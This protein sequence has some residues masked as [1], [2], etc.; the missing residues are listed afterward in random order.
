MVCVG[1]GDAGDASPL[2]SSCSAKGPTSGSIPTKVAGGREFTIISC[3]R[4]SPTSSAWSATFAL[5][6]LL[7][8]RG[9][10]CCPRS[11]HDGFGGSDVVPVAVSMLSQDFLT[12]L[13]I[14]ILAR[15]CAGWATR[16]EASSTLRARR[17]RM[18]RAGRGIAGCRIPS[19]GIGARRPGF[20]GRSGGG[21]AAR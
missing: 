13:K 6:K 12:L 15:Q 16:R 1:A 9:S 14:V 11:S 8:L 21:S 2:R 7:V 19:P 17:L 10:R 4:P 18:F 3:W 5:K 20:R